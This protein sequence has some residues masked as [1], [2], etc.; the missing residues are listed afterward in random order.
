MTVIV[1]AVVAVAL[2]AVIVAVARGIV[3]EHGSF[4]QDSS[5]L[6]PRTNWHQESGKATP[7]FRRADP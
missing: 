1:A 5:V 4:L 7:F 6:G 3:I 2:V